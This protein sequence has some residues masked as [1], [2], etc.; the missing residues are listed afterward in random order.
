MQNNVLYKDIVINITIIYIF[1]L[2]VLA[3]IILH[4]TH[5]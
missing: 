3:A 4:S 1:V 5:L 2:T